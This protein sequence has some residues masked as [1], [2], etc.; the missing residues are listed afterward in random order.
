[1][2]TA[3]ETDK[4]RWERET[5]APALAKLPDRSQPF[6]TISGRPIE[7]LYTA[8]DLDGIDASR[9]IAQP[10]EFPY[11]RGIHPTGY[12][13]KLWTMRQF[14]GF[15][16]PEETNE[17]YKTLLRAGGTGLSVAFDLPTLMGRDPDHELSLGEVG[18]CGVNVTSLADME[19]LFDDIRLSEVTTSM[20]INS[21][22]AMIFA[23][24]LV[25]AEK[26]RADWKQ[27]S[28][29]IQNDILKEFI[30]QKEYI[31]PPRPSMRIITDIFAFCSREVPRWNTISVS[32]YHI[33]E[34]GATAA[35]ELAFTLRDGLEYVRWGVDA[36]LDVDDFVPRMSFFFNAH[37]DFFEEIAKYRA[38][39][40]LWAEAMRDRFGAKSDR[41]WKLRFHTQTAGVSLTAQQPYNNVVR[42][43]LQALSAVLGG[44]NSLH[45]NSLDEAL[46]LPTAEAATLALRTQQVIAHESG[47]ANVVDPLGGSYFVERLTKDME[48]EALAYF[49]RIDRMGGMVEAIE[50]GFPQQEIAESAYRFQQAV[51]RKD[52]IVVGVNGF[53]Q[54]DEPP[55]EIL[56][57]GETASETQL[58]KLA[59]LKRTRDSAAV[60][61]TLDRLG[62]AA[63]GADN[64]MPPILD[65]VRAYATV[66][67]MCDTLREVW[68]EYEEVP[69]I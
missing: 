10:G 12:R 24:Y 47:V 28:G 19:T 6:T 4:Q 25:V 37:S 62:S 57:I 21:P 54:T 69:M 31:F 40:K 8:D 45:T 7:R 53:V 33:R 55:M 59:D 36:G 15:G 32:G 67:E 16:T 20:T 42:T 52:K 44:T 43:A 1:M 34:A 17:R 14:A 23:M 56:Y 48:D 3:A 30:A 58:A 63:R 26:Q 51:E 29:T 13:G 65:A 49:E 5:L 27:L 9:D 64:L 60:R 50:R 38:A 2:K 68:G 22:A 61:R 35:Q 66:G 18:K 11:T 46:A 39:R 41:S